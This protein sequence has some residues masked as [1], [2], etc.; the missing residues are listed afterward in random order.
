M[1][2]KDLDTMPSRCVRWTSAQWCLVFRERGNAALALNRQSSLAS[3]NAAPMIKIADSSRS[4][5]EEGEHGDASESSRSSLGDAVQQRRQHLDQQ[6][7]VS[8]KRRD[9]NDELQKTLLPQHPVFN[10]HVV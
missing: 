4:P 9:A 10:R 1:V 5:R 2:K 3:A 6:H 7:C 8:C